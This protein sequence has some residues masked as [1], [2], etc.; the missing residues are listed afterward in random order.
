MYISR[1][2]HFSYRQRA[3]HQIPKATNDWRTENG[4][5]LHCH[6]AIPLCTLCN[7]VHL[8]FTVFN[9]RFIII[10]VYSFLYTSFSEILARRAYSC[11]C[12]W[13]QSG[14]N[15]CTITQRR[16]QI[17]S[18]ARCFIHI[19]RGMLVEKILEQRRSNQHAHQNMMRPNENNQ[20]NQ[21]R[22]MLASQH[23]IQCG[24]HSPSTIN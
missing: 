20:F 21:C 4:V 13:N 12:A 19:H 16:T 7:R 9:D 6:S 11:M 14:Q 10:L 5:F 24:D 17:T 8:I 15:R 23:D 1:T 18:Q 2:I 22:I 3:L